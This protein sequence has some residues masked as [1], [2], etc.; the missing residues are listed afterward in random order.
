LKVER[1]KIEDALQI[2]NLI[3]QFAERKLML[4]RALS[5]IYEDVRDFVVV[6]NEGKVIACSCLHIYWK[7]LA[8]I[9]SIVVDEGNQGKG[10]G[11]A[12]VDTCILDS[13]SLGIS[14]VFCLTLIPPFFEKLGFVRV[15]KMDLPHKVWAECY[16][17]PKFPDNCDETALILDVK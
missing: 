10:I 5:E 9:R 14:R 17:C 8:E 6:K 11:K 2:Q 4:P 13:Q 12:L 3:N 16:R 1:A 15:D 7:D